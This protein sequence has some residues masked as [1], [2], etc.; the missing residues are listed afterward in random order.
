MLRGVIFFEKTG[1]GLT[2]NDASCY[3]FLKCV[4]SNACNRIYTLRAQFKE[5]LDP[6]IAR[7]VYTKLG[8]RNELPA[9][10]I[11][12]PFL[13]AVHSSPLKNTALRLSKSIRAYQNSRKGK[14]QGKVVGWPRFKSFK[15]EFFSLH[16]EEPLKGYSIDSNL[17][18]A[19]LGLGETKK[20][21]HIE[22]PMPRSK[23]LKDKKVKS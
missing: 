22:I 21:H 8:L 19:S 16:Y 12:K 23:I 15:K 6:E 17:L 10:K 4:T 13:K 3:L 1:G 2:P 20:Q 14:K 11:A 5:I 9:L 18:K 7:I